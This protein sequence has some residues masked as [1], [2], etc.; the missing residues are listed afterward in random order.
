MFEEKGEPDPIWSPH[1]KPD[2]SAYEPNALTLSSPE[3]MLL[4]HFLSTKQSLA[5]SLGQPETFMF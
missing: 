5:D 4:L 3:G 2:P 1:S